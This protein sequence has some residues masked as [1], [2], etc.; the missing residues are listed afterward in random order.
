[1]VV[2]VD[3]ILNIDSLILQDDETV[4]D[5]IDYIRERWS[6]GFEPVV[7]VLYTEQLDGDE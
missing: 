7:E 6:F 4:D 3:C 5:V 2:L 1:M